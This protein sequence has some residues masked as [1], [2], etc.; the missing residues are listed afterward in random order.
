MKTFNPSIFL[1]F[2]LFILC[3]CGPSF[4]V[5]AQTTAIADPAFEQKLIALGIDSDAS[6]N[7]Q[8]SNSDISGLIYLNIS[9]SG[10]T[11]ISGI[12]GFLV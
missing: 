8:V 11:D 9:N 7:G 12:A 3:L 2:F 10:I 1:N 6:L 4:G 5:I